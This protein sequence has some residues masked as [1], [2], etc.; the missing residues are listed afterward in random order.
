MEGKR[1]RSAGAVGPGRDLGG[2]RA[3]CALLAAVLA[4][5][6]PT[7]AA[8]WPTHRGNPQRT[9]NLDNQ[10]GPKAPKVL[11]SFKAAE[12]FIASPVAGDKL[13]Y[14]AGLAGF[15]TA[16][17]HC[18]SLDPAAPQ[19]AAWTKT[20]PF[21]KIPT[22][23]SPAVVE[24]LIVFGDGM[25]QTD[26]AVLYCLTAEGGQAVWQYPV[27]GKLVHLEAGPT[28]D[29]GRVFIGGG[30]AGVLCA[31]LKKV[32]LDGQERDLPTIRAIMDKRWAELAAKYEE[33]KKKDPTFAVPPSED[34]LP[35]PS[36]R[37]VWQ[38]GQGKWHVDAPVAV[39]GDRVLVGSAYI[40]DEKVGK[41][42]LLCL[43]AA[44]GNV[45]WE[46][47]LKVN[48]WAGPSVAGSLVL[49]GCSSIRFD[50]KLI[51]HSAGEVVAVDLAGGQVKW[52]KDVP[53]GVLSPVAIC[54]D[55]AVFTA[56]D[57]RI[58]C[59]SA[60][61]GQEKWS[62]DAG[63]PFFAGPAAA[64]GVI[65][66]ADIKAV[67]HAVSLADGKGIWKLDV[68]GDPAVQLPGMVFGSP[69]V[70]GGM[71]YL[72]T[73]NMETAAA[74][75]PCAVACV[76]EASGAAA[77]V[78]AAGFSVDP[79]RGTITIPCKVAPRKLPSL[80][81]IYPLE[82]VATF[83]S[84][85]GQKA[86]ETVVS[87]EVKPSD[88]HKALEGLGLKPGTPVR[89][90]GVVASGPEVRVFLE[91]PGVAGRPRRVSV[92]KTMMDRRTGKPLPPLKWYF[93]GS[94]MRQTDPTKDTK[95][96]GADMG[97]TLIALFPVTDETVIQTNLT[98]RES[99]L[100]KLETNRDMLGEEGSSVN[101]VIEVK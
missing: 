8:D 9:G 51:P 96:Y 91:V 78:N 22:V 24:G 76:G 82:V 72:A 7:R 98:M 34:A 13:L 99:T 6:L 52:R 100:L 37:L 29:K 40:D 23:C 73:C 25:H 68:S 101:L 89:G 61:D 12:H 86:H 53:G 48:P 71:I 2:A 62:Y 63:V 59:W 43:N 45:L 56:T 36:P 28:V 58:R 1:T 75:Q 64:G 92:E 97:G 42:S 94:V 57:G 81:E 49:V 85:R 83:P 21:I 41:R 10:A 84:P 87:F 30:E 15:N 47:P 80:Q 17:F 69:I 5:C 16:A 4:A 35:M 20:A 33:D 77:A 19:R 11:W 54:G 14:V 95:A 93:T 39:V 66:A 90:E 32:M 60:Q 27:P 79:S 38:A 3:A 50:Q 44:D 74:D 70:Q 65:Y 67:L 55:L 46:V 18:L 26:G 88:V 31:D